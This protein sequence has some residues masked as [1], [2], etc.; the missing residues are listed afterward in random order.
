MRL[1]CQKLDRDYEIELRKFAWIFIKLHCP[2]WL[3]DAFCVWFGSHFKRMQAW[4]T[5]LKHIDCIEL[6]REQFDFGIKEASCSINNSQQLSSVPHWLIWLKIL[7]FT[8]GRSKCEFDKILYES[9]MAYSIWSG[10]WI[11]CELSHSY[12]GMTRL[13]SWNILNWFHIPTG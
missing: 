9:K 2:K 10:G 6:N 8:N 13:E 3:F 11:I 7:S 1:K 5:W 12:D 4:C